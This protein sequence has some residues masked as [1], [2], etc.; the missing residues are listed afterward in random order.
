MGQNPGYLLKS[1]YFDITIQYKEEIKKKKKPNR[2]FLQKGL[3]TLRPAGVGRE[4]TKVMM[5]IM[6]VA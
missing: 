4:V 3:A 2:G 6:L 1:F 5:I